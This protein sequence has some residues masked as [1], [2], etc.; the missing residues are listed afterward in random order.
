MG[1][2]ISAMRVS[3]YL[4]GLG[5]AAIKLASMPAMSSSTYENGGCAAAWEN[6]GADSVTIGSNSDEFG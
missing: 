1:E 2:S 5:G 3:R 6:R 4:M